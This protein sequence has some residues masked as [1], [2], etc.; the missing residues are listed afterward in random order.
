MTI[1]STDVTVPMYMPPVSFPYGAAHTTELQFIFPHFH[2]GSGTVHPLS[3]G[4]TALAATMQTYWTNFARTGDPNN[5]SLPDWPKFTAAGNAVLSLAVPKP[6][7]ITN[8]ADQ[9]RCG[10]WDTLN[11]Y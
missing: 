8:F 7:V 1:S 10:F 5:G 11:D 9:H 2:G 6:A 3:V 4:E